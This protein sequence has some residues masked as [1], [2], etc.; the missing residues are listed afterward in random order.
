M[1]KEYFA[2]KGKNRSGGGPFMMGS[3]GQ[4]KN[5]I[6]MKSPM[7]EVTTWEKIKAAGKGLKAGVGRALQASRTENVGYSTREG[8]KAGSKARKQA[9]KEY[10]KD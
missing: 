5:P 9:L 7:K 10:D 4:G 2:K 8:V 3:Y 6:M 1:P